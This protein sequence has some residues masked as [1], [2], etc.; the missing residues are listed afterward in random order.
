MTRPLYLGPGVRRVGLDGPALRILD[1]DGRETSIPLRLISRV[2]SRARAAFAVE[3]LTGCL[4]HGI[5]VAFLEADGTPVGLCLPM[6]PLTPSL[7]DKLAALES[8]PHGREAFANWA[9]SEERRSLL[10]AFGKAFPA[11]APP[12]PEVLHQRLLGLV[13]SSPQRAAALW[14][15]LEGLA[16][17]HL[18][19]LLLG[20]GLPPHRAAPASA[21]RID[22]FS[23]CLA[24]ARWELFPAL[25]RLARHRAEHPAKWQAPRQRA[26][27]LV[28][29]YETIAPHIAASLRRRLARLEEWLWDPLR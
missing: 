27:R 13:D 25:R 11:L 14:Q 12:P 28:R 22:L 23:A 9:R 24:A 29:A 4:A 20:A 17:A 8:E 16:A 26:E 1:Q 19:E 5:P 10:A 15:G 7:E 21:G 18:G 2:V 6:R 3:A